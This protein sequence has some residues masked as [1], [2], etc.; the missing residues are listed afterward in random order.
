MRVIV[1]PFNDPPVVSAGPDQTIIWPANTVTLA[2]IATDDGLP[3]GSILKT[4][5]AFVSGPTAVLFADSSALNTTVQF[6]SPGTYVLR[7]TADD[8]QFRSSD[9]VTLIVRSLIDGPPKIISTPVTQFITDPSASPLPTYAYVV[10]AT[11][12]ENDPLEYM[13]TAFPAGMTIDSV[14]G[15]ITWTPTQNDLGP[16]TVSVKVREAS[17]QFD[18]QSYVLNVLTQ[19]SVSPLGTLVLSPASA[20]PVV[21]GTAQ[22]LQAIFTDAN[23]APVANSVITFTVTG[24][25]ATTGTAIT[26]SSGKAKFVYSGTASGVDSIVASVSAGSSTLNSNTSTINWVVPAQ[27]IS[28]TTINGRI[29]FSNGSG[30]FNTPPTATPAFVQNFPTINFNPPTGTVPGMPGSIGVNTRPFTDVTTDLNGNFTG[31]IVVQGNGVQAGVGSLFDFQAVFTG[32]YTV[33]AAGNVTFNFFSDDGFIFGVDNGATRVSGSLFNPPPSGLTPFQG[34]PVMGSFNTATAPVANSITVHFPGPGTYQYEIDYSECCGGELA[35]TMTSSLSGNHGVPSS[36]TVTLVPGTNIAKNIGQTATFTALLTDASGAIIP[37]VPVLFNVAGANTLQFQG[38]SDST[39]HA[40]FSYQGFRTGTDIVQANAQITGMTAVSNQTLVTWNSAANTA[41]VV[42]AGTNQTIT[43]PTNSATLNG[44]A[45]DDGLPNG[46]LTTTWTQVSGPVQAAIASPNQ[47]VTVVSFTQPGSYVFKLTA[48]D[49]VLTSSANVTITVNQQNLAPFITI[50]VDSTVI[51]QPANTVHVTGTATDDGFPTGST[52]TT[53][54]TQVS[55]PAAATVSNPNSPNTSITFPAAGTYVLKLSASD[56]QLTSSVS[57]TIT[58]NP[59]APN[60]APTVAITASQTLLTLPSNVVI[61]A[62]KISD[63]GLPLGAAIT[64]QWSQVSGPLPVTFSTPASSSTQVGF[65]TAGTYVLQLAASDSQLTGS[66]TISITVNAI[67][68]NQ[69]PTVAIIADHTSITL[70]TNTVTLN[71]VINDDGLPNGT[72][73]TQ[74]AQISGPVAVNIAQVTST[75]VKVSFPATGVYV[76]KLTA[77]D[78]QLAS[79]ATITITVTTS[80]GNQPP[81]VSAGPSQSLQL[82]QNTLTLTG[83]A[84]DDGLPTGSTLLVNWSQISGSATVSFSTPGSVVTQASFPVAGVYVLQL[85]ANDS[86]LQTTAQVTVTVVNAPVPPPT[87]PSVSLIGFADGA[88]ITKPTPIIG[89]VTTGNWKLEYSLLD[90]SGNPTTFTTFA[91]GTAPVTNATLG[92]FDPTVLLNGQYI[93]RFSS[94]DNA[95]QTSTT[96]STVDVSRN[97]K[98]GN[99]TLVIQRSF[100]ASART[101]HHHHAHLRLAR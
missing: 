97:T 80:G 79:E 33:A 100:R 69:A 94:T 28:T 40:T 71:G 47:L 55:G 31:S 14:T 60:Q 44:T 72:I 99:F 87:P 53:Q 52:L 35:V 3:T 30:P 25:N 48:S 76:I 13:L 22:Q 10:V 84:A 63:D 101:A 50:S 5:W 49:S 21:V 6:N 41:P 36:G 89:S 37:N 65:P 91:S 92:T 64:T 83:Y 77:N 16:H 45:T 26:D 39:G 51:T 59:P 81:T 8:S 17:G 82:P 27:P 58:V 9:D 15:A 70:P 19:A 73:S 85:S 42:H 34:Y 86:Q 43:L 56:S 66:A 96:S 32:S 88:D 67:G 57:V 62:G 93:V 23:N 78:G 38:V 74:W 61:L 2:G 54:W 95:G 4:N 24:P 12:P 1:L 90:G 20:G 98:V 46:T 7:L 18:T 29:F 11:D 75:S 68:T